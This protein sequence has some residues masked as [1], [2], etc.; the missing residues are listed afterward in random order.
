MNK[1]INKRTSGG[2]AVPSSIRNKLTVNQLLTA[3]KLTCQYFD[4]RNGL[5]DNKFNCMP[6]S[7]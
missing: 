1:E 5:R 6:K 4:S 2:E 7:V 3:V